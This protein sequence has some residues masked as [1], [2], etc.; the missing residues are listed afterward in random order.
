MFGRLMRFIKTKNLQLNRVDKTI[1]QWDEDLNSPK[2]LMGKMH[3]VL[4]MQRTDIRQ[5]SDAEF[6]V[7]SQFG[8]DGIIQ[9]I[10]NKIDF[11]NHTFIEFGV[12]NYRQSNT[13]FL[14][15]NNDWAGFVIDGSDENIQYIKKDMISWACELHAATAFITSENINSLLTIPGFDSEI[16]I[17]SIDIDG[18]DYWV[19]KA[20]DV[21]NPVMV[22]VEYNS[23]FGK[24]TK[25]T[26]PYDASFQRSNKL[27][28]GASLGA[29]CD[30]AEAKGYSFVGSNSKGLNA[31]FL[32]NDK[33]GTFKKMSTQEGYVESKFREFI[34]DGIRLSGKDRIKELKGFDVYDLTQKAIIKIN[35][36]E[37]EY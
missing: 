34:R 12:E 37:V 31:Y 2:L 4:N 14:L 9:H 23:V 16:G 30:L 32:R 8:D 19:W 28:F 26:I 3:T 36:D 15:L 35:S 11:P 21:I 20:I 18:N 7:F 25:W 27:Y 13:R 33:M 6:Q 10:I 5:I 17:L 24:N 29:F 22:I 1:S